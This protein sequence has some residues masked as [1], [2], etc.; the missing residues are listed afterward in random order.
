MF[1]WYGDRPSLSLVDLLLAH[2]RS[3]VVLDENPVSLTLTCSLVGRVGSI[4]LD[5]CVCVILP[6]LVVYV[7]LLT[8]VEFCGGCALSDSI[9]YL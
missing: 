4:I 7:I 8:Y 2:P 3:Y 9:L 6:G 1:C 5:L